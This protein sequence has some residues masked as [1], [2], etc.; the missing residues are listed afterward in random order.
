MLQVW[1]SASGALQE[2]TNMYIQYMYVLN[3]EFD[4][5]NRMC[6]VLLGAAASYPQVASN[7]QGTE[8]NKRACT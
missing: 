8:S 2:P 3:A 5:C 7:A 4:K 1:P 6:C